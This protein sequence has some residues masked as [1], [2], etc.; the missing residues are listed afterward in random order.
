YG[1]GRVGL[2]GQVASAAL[3]AGGEVVGVIPHSLAR[4]EIAQADCTELIVV[5]TMHQR[6]AL[7]A[8]RADAFVALPGG[9]GTCDELFEIITWSQLGIHAKPVALLNVN[10]FFSPLL[11]WLD[12]ITAEGLLKPHHRDLLLASDTV[13]HLFD[14]LANWKPPEPITKWAEPEER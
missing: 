8:D 12:H 9:F 7:M 11:A 13:P 3:A 5:D 14:V 10:G 4:K 6:K 2:M 1:G